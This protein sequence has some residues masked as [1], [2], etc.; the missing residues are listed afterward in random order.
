MLKR[1]QQVLLAFNHAFGASENVVARTSQGALA[2]FGIRVLCRHRNP[3]SRSRW[4]L[5]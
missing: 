2:P 5:A 3:V 4:A 1:C